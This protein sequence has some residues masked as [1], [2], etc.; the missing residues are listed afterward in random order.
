M[1]V[2]EII[3]L[4]PDAA[5]IMTEYGMHCSSCSI[6]A[7]ET[8][9]EGAG[10][11]GFDDEVLTELLDD[12]NIAL[13]E[14]PAK[15]HVLTITPEAAKKVQVIAEAEN[16]AV[17]VLHVLVD[18]MGGFCLEFAE[19]ELADGKSFSCAE[20][21]SVVVSASLLVLNR[22][23]GAVIDFREDRFKLDLPDEPSACCKGNADACGCTE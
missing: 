2:G 12:L 10:M 1:R 3:A 11:H 23:G 13:A 7:V 5:G 8:L 22:I 15:E 9:A 17:P 20:V 6:G 4:L 18:T 16:V 21:P 14:A 19:E